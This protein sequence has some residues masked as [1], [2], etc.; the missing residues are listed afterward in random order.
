MAAL[1]VSWER[2]E[3]IWLG[4]MEAEIVISWLLRKEVPGLFEIRTNPVVHVGKGSLDLSECVW[5]GN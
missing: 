4:Q 3:R 5:A 2:K 1:A